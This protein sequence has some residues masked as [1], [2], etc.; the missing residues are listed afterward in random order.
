M[1]RF[2]SA[3]RVTT[4]L[5][6]LFAVLFPPRVAPQKTEPEVSVQD[7]VVTLSGKGDVQPKS[8]PSGAL[9]TLR[10][11]LRNA[12][13]QKASSFRFAVRINGKEVDTY[14][15]MLYFQAIHPGAT[16]EI[17]L[18]NFYSAEPQAK[19]GSMTVEVTIREAR[20]VEIKKEGEAQTWIPT[21][22]VKGLPASKS[23]SIPITV[24]PK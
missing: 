7:I 22:E 18:H 11:K 16:G 24:A 14:D 3:V 13:A 4:L 17:A 2:A 10:V 21:G 15:K 8:L 23:I 6:P 19:G 1:T 9:C 5:L 20:W 12:G